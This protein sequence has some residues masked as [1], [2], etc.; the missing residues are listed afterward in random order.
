MG[1]KVIPTSTSNVP[2]WIRLCATVLNNLITLSNG[3]RSVKEISANYT[4]EYNDSFLLVNVAGVTVTLDGV[5][6]V[7]RKLFIKN[8]FASGTTTVSG[9]IDGGTSIAITTSYGSTQ[10]R[11]DGVQWWSEVVADEAILSGS[12]WDGESVET[13]GD[14]TIGGGLV[15]G[16]PGFEGSGITVHGTTFNST[17]KV[18]DL[19]GTNPAQTILHRHSTT[20]PPAIVGARSHSNTSA[21][22]IVQDGDNLLDIFALG[23]DG[24]DYE[25]AAGIRAEVDGTP[26]N[27]DMPGRWVIATTPPGGFIP[28]DA[29]KVDSSQNVTVLAGDFIVSSGGEVFLN[30]PTSAGTTGSLWND[31]GTVK[32]A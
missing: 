22:A 2:A 6:D 24:T 32:V 29:L 5:N 1:F 11:S 4:T 26:G 12:Y 14:F 15:V 3:E 18:S 17:F 28:I 19:G 10:L 30:L 27:N 25:I 13:T 16:D 23:H 7:G 31:T 8:G 20:L 21:H 9:D